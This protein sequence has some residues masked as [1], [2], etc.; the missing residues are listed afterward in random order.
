LYFPY[1]CNF[2]Y[3]Y[4]DGKLLKISAQLELIIWRRVR[5]KET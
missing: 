5:E 2:F 4:L 3:N 1:I